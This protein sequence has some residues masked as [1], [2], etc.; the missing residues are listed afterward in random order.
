MMK[1]LTVSLG[2]MFAA[3]SAMS[4]IVAPRKGGAAKAAVAASKIEVEKSLAK[5]KE[6]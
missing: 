5:A 4:M 3:F 1:K 6:V 2:S